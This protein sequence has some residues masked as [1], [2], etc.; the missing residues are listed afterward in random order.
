M[1]FFL[2]IT[3]SGLE[4]STFSFTS[5]AD[6]WRFRLKETEPVRG[7]TLTRVMLV[8]GPILLR[9]INLLT[10][11]HPYLCSIPLL[12]FGAKPL[13]VCTNKLL[14]PIWRGFLLAIRLRKPTSRASSHDRNAYDPYAYYRAMGFNFYND[15]YY[16]RP[17][18]A[19]AR[20]GGSEDSK[21]WTVDETIG[22]MM[23]ASIGA[24]G[25]YILGRHWMLW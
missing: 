12:C 25:G 14:S 3:S 5:F 10:I 6:S 11:N 20:Y 1:V 7:A 15:P 2:L 17:G 8:Q 18:P 19:V 23:G 9:D 13:Y 21:V 24:W 22:T 4:S 16:Y